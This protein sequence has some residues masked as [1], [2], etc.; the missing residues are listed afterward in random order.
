MTVMM[1]R[2]NTKTIIKL[3]AAAC[4]IYF[5]FRVLLADREAYYSTTRD[6][7]RAGQ[8]HLTEDT[9]FD[10]I[11]NETLGFQHI[12]AIGMKERTDKRDYLT[13]AASFLGIKVDWRDGVYPDSVVEK[14]YPLKL[15]ESG[16]KPAAIGCWRAHMNTLIDIVENQYTTALILE[17][18]ADWD[19]S[20]RQQ[21]AEFARG[22]RTLTNNQKES[23][24][25]PYG[26]NWD[27]L[28]VGG[29]AS[30]AKQNETNF[31][32]IPNDPT[33]PNTS[34]RGPWE[35]PA[36][37]SIKWREEHPE[38]PVDSTRYIYRANMGCCTFGY[39]VTLEGARRILAE[40]SVNYLNLPVDNA[41]SDLCAGSN[42]PQLKCYAPFPNL[43]GTFR[44]EGYV[45]RDSDIDQWEDRKFEWH[46]ALSYN[47]V[48]STRLN[49]HRLVAG[50]QTVYSQWKES[51]DPWSKAEV[52]L[53]ELEYPRGVI[54]A[55]YRA[56][57]TQVVIF[58]TTVHW[59]S[60]NRDRA[61]PLTSTVGLSSIR[62][63]LMIKTYMLFSTSEYMNTN[64]RT[65]LS[66]IYSSEK[67]EEDPEAGLLIKSPVKYETDEKI[68]YASDHDS[69]AS[70]D[71]LIPGA[72]FIIWTGINILS[73][74][75]IVFTNKSILSDPSF[76]NCQ[77][78]FAAY[79]FFV[80][81]ATLWAASR[82]WCG[83]FV[84]KSVA[85]VQMLP[86]AAAMC[87]Q[88]I[89][90]NL[91]LAHSSVM[92]HQLARLLL[93]P[94]TA[95]LNYL[96]YGAKVPRAATLPLILLCAGVGMVSYYDSLPTTDGQITT[97][98]SGIIFAFSGVGASAIYTVW[99]GHYHKKL[100][101]SSMQLLLNQA[102]VSAGLLLCTIPLI[103][104]PPTVSSVPESTWVL[105]FMSGIFAC[106][107]NLSGFYIIDAA[108]PVSSTVIG[109]LKTCIIVGL[110]WA[111]SRHVVMRQSI[112]GIFMALVG[113]S[114]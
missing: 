10:H 69:E 81:G 92:F 79:H 63:P 56:R 1:S 28:W 42:R 44:S 102:P 93:T 48:F 35:S 78:S 6:V 89:L 19:V 31:Y 27:I 22:V 43:I 4:C 8:H 107:V 94:V 34:I 50:E 47:M 110:G 85:I 80:T 14:A 45:S 36:G 96:L 12:Y 59:I 73:T 39:A 29:C 38:W 5:L 111:S 60:R 41:M 54:E 7:I 113:M 15:S 100:E 106:L 84:P 20:L 83:F 112:L 17:D 23:K 76:R 68:E 108:G 98:L 57:I 37:P 86:L 70:T 65:S 53:G 25:A 58:Q 104:T 90:Q 114:M 72:G 30:G 103:E 61:C 64:I 91:G 16:V 67:P 3:V 62:S 87:I 49:I 74:V 32:V 97:S 21:L 40:L 88:V 99:I 11:N 9:T 52:K 77:A 66:M 95:L 2:W 18:D 75:A 46:Q 26:T 55:T 24:K 13:L 82:P 101:M 51:P 71:R 33:V 105:I 109:Q